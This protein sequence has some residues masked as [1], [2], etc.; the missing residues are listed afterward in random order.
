MDYSATR[1]LRELFLNGLT[2]L[3]KAYAHQGEFRRAANLCR[4]SLSFDDSRES[5]YRAL[6]LYLYCAGE[7]AAALHVNEEVRSS[8]TDLARVQL[9]LARV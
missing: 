8:H 6:M 7:P 5:A 4:Y 3:A 1:Q 2:D 9:R